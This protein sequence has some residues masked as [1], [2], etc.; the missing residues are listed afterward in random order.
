LF[1]LLFT[2]KPAERQNTKDDAI[3]FLE[4][5]MWCPVLPRNASFF[6]PK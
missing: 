3:L 2:T 4:L 5:L 6:A 1:D